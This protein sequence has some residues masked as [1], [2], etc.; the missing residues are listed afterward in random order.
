MHEMRPRLA[1]GTVWVAVPDLTCDKGLLCNGGAHLVKVELAAFG[2]R[3]GVNRTLVLHPKR[4]SVLL[5][6]HM[7]IEPADAP[8]RFLIETVLRT[9][10]V[11]LQEANPGTCAAVFS[12]VDDIM[13]AL[14]RAAEEAIA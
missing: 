4:P 3:V 13:Q 2:G 9:I 14:A 11:G 10:R 5:L 8:A 12:V 6:D 7:E 1:T